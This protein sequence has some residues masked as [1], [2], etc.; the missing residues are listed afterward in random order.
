MRARLSMKTQQQG[1]SLIELMV[2]L[3]IGLLLVVGVLQAFVGSKQ[4]YTMQ[5]GLAKLQENGRFAMSFLAR[6]L[7][8]AGYTGCSRSS[9]ISNTLRDPGNGNTL[10]S[11]L[12][13]NTSINGQDSA[14]GAVIGG[15]TVFGNSDVVEVRF[16]DTSGGCDLEVGKHNANSAT[17]HCQDNHTFQK[18]DIL[19][20][21]DCQTTAIFQQSNVNN[22]GTVSTIVHNTGNGTDIGNCTSFLGSPVNCPTGTKYTFSTGSVL[23]VLFYRYFIALNTHGEPALYREEISNNSGET[24]TQARELVEGVENMQVLYGEDDNSDGT[25]DHYVPIDE[26]TNNQEIISI[27]VS[28]LVRSSETSIARDGQT[29]TFNGGAV[30]FNDGRLRKVFTSTIALRNRL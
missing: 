20:V 5:S 7:R 29:L 15:R 19:V 10:P 28:L 3:V 13:F 30:N 8:Q 24:E 2:S 23:R 11:Y 25:V 4:T 1:F 18:G 26:V 22:N 27:R 17:L 16:A 12:D 21:T 6:D 9:Q 14:S